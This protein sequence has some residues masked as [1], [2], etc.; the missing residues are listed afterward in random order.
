M[1]INSFN[2]FSLIHEI[3]SYIFLKII[4]IPHERIIFDTALVIFIIII[5][6]YKKVNLYLYQYKKNYCSFM[7]KKVKDKLKL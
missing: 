3:A 2:I 6:F 1:T 7:F 4:N 5:Y